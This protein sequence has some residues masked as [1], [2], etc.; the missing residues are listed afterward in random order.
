MLLQARRYWKRMAHLRRDGIPATGT[1]LR[2]LK[3]NRGIVHPVIE[4]H[5]AHG[6]RIE[7]IP[8][9]G[10]RTTR[11]TGSRV[12]VIYSESR[13]HVAQINTASRMFAAPLI[14]AVSGLAFCC[15]GAVMLFSP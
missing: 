14:F 2:I 12:D 5:D 7:F 6:R 15:G 4:F 10:Y 1:V 9:V 13:P 11:P 8:D 3:G